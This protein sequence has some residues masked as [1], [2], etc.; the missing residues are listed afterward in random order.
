MPE[1][2]V[3]RDPCVTVR[4]NVYDLPESTTKKTILETILDV[5]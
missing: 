5:I 2:D 3:N 1:L 4:G